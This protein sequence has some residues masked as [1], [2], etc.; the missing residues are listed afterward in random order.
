MTRGADPNIRDAQGFN[1]LHLVT[2]S[3]AVMPMLYMLQQPVA[4]D[5]KDTDGHTALMWAAYQGDGLSVELLLKHG[6]S[7][8]TED[9]A[10][11]TPLHWAVV[12]GSPVCMSHLLLAGADYN[13]R[14]GSGKTPRDMGEELK[15]TTALNR[16]LED[17][18]Y[19]MF[20]L[21][22]QSYFSP[23]VTMTLM[24]TVPTLALLGTFV[25]FHFLPGYFSIPLAAGLFYGMFY[26]VTKI[27]LRH[28]PKH[29]RIQ[30][31]PFYAAIITGSLIWVFYA[32]ASRL[33]THT[34]GYMWSNISFFVSFVLCAGFFYLA[35][36]TDPGF[37]PKPETE[38]ETK[39][40]IEELTDQG[41]LNG[42]N[43]CIFCMIRK[44]LRSKHCK[45]CNHCVARFDHHCPWVW[46]C[47]GFNNH[48]SFLLFV[49]FLIT[50]IISFNSLVIGY[51]GE[52]APPYEEPEDPT[53][54]MC[55]VSE[56]FCRATAYD[57]FLLAVAFWAT[58]Q[59]TW[60][61]VLA[62]SH[63]Y[64]I[65]VQM[66]TFEISNLGRYGYM[67]G[68]GGTSLRD[69]SGAQ[70]QFRPI[71]VEGD[72]GTSPSS[73]PGPSGADGAGHVHGPECKHGQGHGHHS[74]RCGFLGAV[75]G[76]AGKLITGPLFRLLGFDRFTKGKAVSGLA[77]AGKDQNPFDMGM[78]KVSSKGVSLTD[79]SRTAQTSGQRPTTSTSSVYTTFPTRAG[80]RTAAKRWRRARQAR[81]D[82]RPCPARRCNEVKYIRSI[83]M[84]VTRPSLDDICMHE[85]PDMVQVVGVRS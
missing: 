4:I 32:W 78:I 15:S 3:S 24:F 17:A 21:P 64:Q 30:G 57:T 68:R 16:A 76:Q 50:G 6:A 41:R 29:E 49:I 25:G 66:T 83:Y 81:T 9:N 1:T 23:R 35:I 14:E 11:L 79:I 26:I 73:S 7:V 13:A 36:V 12:K 40:A 72:D 34:S 70:T 42:T 45:L 63:L 77:R 74:H 47:V 61:L 65:G 60:T 46:N 55:N 48:R 28:V 33:A 19:D 38:E 44:P 18:N 39:G 67:G 69:Q 84:S 8:H 53:F 54:T 37:V 31:S 82:T 5:E 58:L 71:A 56:T 80:P 51:F 43:F 59:L 62:A 10:G 85:C 2:H 75:C 27:L 20:G 52:N 22:V